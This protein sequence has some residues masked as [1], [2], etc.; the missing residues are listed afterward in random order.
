MIIGM[1]LFYYVCHH[2]GYD[3]KLLEKLGLVEQHYHTDWSAVGWERSLNKMSYDADIVFFGDSI[4]SGS[5]F[6]SS[7]AN[8]TIVELG[9]PGD[10]IIGMTQRIGMVKA[11]SPEKVFILGG[12]NSLTDYNSDK[13]L[14]QY[15]NMIVSLIDLLPSSEIYVQSILPISNEQE[16]AVCHNESIL[17]FNKDLESLCFDLQVTY[18]DLF[19]L[20]EQEGSM[21]P[22]L[23]K[24]GIHLNEDGYSLWEESIKKYIE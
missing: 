11:L 13:V 7:F 10:T 15:R 23:T 5:E 21:N 14:S 9:I 19:S 22:D 24:D 4:T 18:V 8:K 16:I 3:V 20:Y 1:C 17:S 6:Q 12:I 2:A